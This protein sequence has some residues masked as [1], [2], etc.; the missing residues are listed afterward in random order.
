MFITFEGGEGAGKTTLIQNLS[1]RLIQEGQN[2]L[3]TRAP[4]GTSMG[5]LIRELLL[6]KE[7]L[8]A[9]SELFLFLADRAEHVDEVIKPAL[10]AGS[11]VLCD[12]YNDSTVAYQGGAR[13]FD[14]EWIK[15]LCAFATQELQPDLTFYL[16]IDPVQGLERVKNRA[17]DR[18]ESE[19]MGFHQTIRST[20]LRLAQEDQK[21]FH[22]LNA[23]LASDAVF[24]AALHAIRCKFS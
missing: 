11:V 7:H 8:N 19:N 2:V 18:I 9:R 13:G 20:Y 3:V 22:I 1:Q 15:Q 4:G 12:R 10:Q 21:R 6:H 23:E 14:C 17:K 5:A 24:K 16:D